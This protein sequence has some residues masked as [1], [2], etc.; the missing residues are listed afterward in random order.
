MLKKLYKWMYRFSKK[1]LGIDEKEWSKV[2]VIETQDFQVIDYVSI[3]K[4]SNLERTVL[5]ADE[6]GLSP[7]GLMNFELSIDGEFVDRKVGRKKYVE[8]RVRREHYDMMF[9]EIGHFVTKLV[10]HGTFDTTA[11][12]CITK[13]IKRK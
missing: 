12:Q 7:D 1:R 3:H 6:V 8:D 11:V 5:F 2:A 13:V 10:G 4:L 9:K